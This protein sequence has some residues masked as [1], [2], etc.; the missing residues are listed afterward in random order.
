MKKIIY[1]FAMAA[2]LFSC[3]QYNE[4]NFPG[5]DADVIT[6]VN[7]SLQYSLTK[8]DYQSI[9]KSLTTY[10]TAD[11]PDTTAIPA[12]LDS[13]YP[14]MDDGSAAMVTYSYYTG[15]DVAYQD[16]I[17]GWKADDAY[18]LT[19]DDYT[20]MGLKYGDFSSSDKPENYLPDF[21]TA[22]YDN[23]SDGFS[24]L[25][26]Y[27]YYG[28][29]TTS[30]VVAEYT[31][32]VVAINADENY[33]LQKADYTGMGLSYSDFSSSAPPENY[34]PDFLLT[35]YPDAQ[36]GEVVAITYAYYNGTSTVDQT[37]YYQF[38]GTTWS[39]LS[40]VVWVANASIALPADVSTH[41]LTT[42]DYTAMG[43]DNFNTAVTTDSYLPKYLSVNYPYAK[44]GDKVALL[45]QYE[46]DEASIQATEYTL[47]DSAWVATGHS[48]T[49]TNQ[50][51]KSDG[52]WK[53]E[54]AVMYTMVK[55]IE[56]TDDYQL[57]I[58]YVEAN[59]GADHLGSLYNGVYESED[60]YGVNSYYGEFQIKDQYWNSDMFDS[61]NDAAIAA[62]GNAFLPQK[63]PDATVG[64]KYIITFAG[65]VSSMVDYQ[66]TFKCKAAGSVPTFELVDGPTVK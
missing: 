6:Y 44:V 21:L 45:Y 24:V 4:G 22:K 52:V 25:I 56:S 58:N 55:G 47:T 43:I 9:D 65:Y 48:T 28:G 13:N 14:Y 29:G 10:L 12:F 46:G 61:W 15:E 32:K 2:A 57:I 8:S 38:D 7:D 17:D 27:K 64:T 1:L 60:Y 19:S 59:F 66:I 31:K 36:S 35:K 5:G 49:V 34:L 54:T 26:T 51:V 50:F 40:P 11:F 33:T 41:T 63:Y 20:T 23:E 53:L 39:K 42:A 3:D 62:I 37:G 16:T 30:D 18:E